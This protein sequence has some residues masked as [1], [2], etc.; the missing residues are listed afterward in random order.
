MR[1]A[2]LRRE[3][4]DQ[5][6]RTA[7]VFFLMRDITRMPH[8]HSVYDATKCTRTDDR[9]SNSAFRASLVLLL[10]FPRS[11][12]VQA[13]ILAPPPPL[14]EAQRA[15]LSEISTGGLNESDSRT[16]R[17]GISDRPEWCRDR[18]LGNLP[19]S[20]GSTPRS[21]S[22]RFRGR[23]T[24][25]ERLGRKPEKYRGRRQ[26]LSRQTEAQSKTLCF[27]Q[28]RHFNVVLVVRCVVLSQWDLRHTE[29]ITTSTFAS[30]E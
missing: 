5:T 9:R 19:Q 16:G 13:E 15:P 24:W 17:T 3:S 10:R 21:P 29:M 1:P 25:D 23:A 6:R 8:L 26:N 12:R 11:F 27:E 14:P 18:K 4:R 22:F 28:A 30:K 20:S 7:C 2:R